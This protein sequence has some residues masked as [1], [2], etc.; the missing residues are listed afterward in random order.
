VSPFAYKCGKR[1]EHMQIYVLCEETS[2]GI[3]EGNGFI[4]LSGTK[5]V[6]HRIKKQNTQNP[7]KLKQLTGNHLEIRTQ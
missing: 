3:P 1:P 2:K 7:M 4:L 5:N 6:D